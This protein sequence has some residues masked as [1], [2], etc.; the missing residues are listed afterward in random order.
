[1]SMVCQTSVNG[2]RLTRLAQ[3]NACLVVA[4]VMGKEAAKLS[5][6]PGSIEGIVSPNTAAGCCLAQPRDSK[7]PGAVGGA[8]SASSST[9]IVP[10]KCCAYIIKFP[11]KGA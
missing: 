2:I 10:Y 1:M 6:S 11:G 7:R 5:G 4:T 3:Q 9:A 8:K